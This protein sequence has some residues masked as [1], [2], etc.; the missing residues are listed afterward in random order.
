MAN[1]DNN[2]FTLSLPTEEE[3]KKEVEEKAKVDE[4]KTEALTSAAEQQVQAVMNID[5][6]DVSQRSAVMKT[7]ENFGQDAVVAS[8]RKNDFL[9][10]RIA[11][12][13]SDSDET[14]T[15]ATNL[16]ELSV[17][18][19]E[20]DPSG[21]DFSKGFKN[22]IMNPVRRY[23]TKYEKADTVIEGILTVITNGEKT[24]R[25]DNKTLLIEQQSLEEATAKLNEYIELGN[26]F[27][28]ALSQ[29][30]E[31][32]KFDGVD[33]KKITFFETEVLFPLRQKIMDMG[34]LLVVNYQGIG[35]IDVIRKNNLELIRGVDR[36]K[37]VSVAA[38][39]IGVMCAQAL[40][41]QK[42][43]LTAVQ[44]LNDSTT[45][46]IEANAQMLGKQSGAIQEMSAN[47]MIA[48]ETLQESFRTVFDVMDAC[49]EYKRE[50][51]PQMAQT[52]QTFIE[53]GEE[54]KERVE[55]MQAA[56]ELKDANE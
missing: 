3:I 38:L 19:K 15:V 51:L 5:L 13:K 7:I 49:E 18:M 9:A 26:Q 27:D 36:A 44:T 17:Q 43:V 56:R 41:N 12:F 6:T 23:F 10:K 52:V 47:P 54:G 14:S 28:A 48:I 25:N 46:M 40:Y 16:T 2:K 45:K 50:A 34:T 8:Q 20:L 39:R 30:I 35:A 1:T 37:Q 24:L 31:Q 29:A 21:I 22:K 53:L 42:L 55:R 4:E 11:T 32:A 33:D